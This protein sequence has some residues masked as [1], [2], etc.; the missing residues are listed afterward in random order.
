MEIHERLKQARTKAGY[1][2]AQ[3][4]A[5]AFGW[6]PVT[7]RAHEAGDRGI[8]KPVAEKYARAFRVPFEWLYLGKGTSD[9]ETAEIVNIWDRIPD[10][11]KESARR[12]LEGLA[13]P[14]KTGS[15]DE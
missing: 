10:R 13:Q 6:N 12:M 8:R 2:H 14:F 7:Y 15:D 9:N 11:D 3:D 4:A 1:E 5:E